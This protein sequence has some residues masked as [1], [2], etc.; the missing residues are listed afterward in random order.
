V[1]DRA[2]LEE[3]LPEEALPEHAVR[4]PAVRRQAVAEDR[5]L[6]GIAALVELSVAPEVVHPE[7]RAADEAL[8]LAA[9]RPRRFPRPSS[10]S[11]ALPAILVLQAAL[12]LRLIWSNTAYQDESLYLWAGRLELAHWSHGAP[13]PAFQTYLS[14]SPAVYPPLAA[15]ANDVGGLAAARILSLLFMLGA[16]CLLYG[17]TVRLLNR[18]SAIAAAALFA[19]FG[20]GTEL[21]AFATYDAMAV[22]LTALAAYLVVRAGPARIGEP[23]LVAAGAVLALAA[24]TKYAAALWAPVVICLAALTAQHGSW[25]RRALRATR[26]SCYAAAPAAAALVAAGGSYVRGVEFTTVHRQ[27]VTATPPLRVLDIAWGWLAL[28][29]LLGVLGVVLIWHDQ[30]RV[31]IIPLVL[32]SAALLAPVAQARIHD[33][34]SLH[35]QVVFGAWFLCAV[36]G[37]AVG[38]ISFLDGKLSQGAVIGS[39]LVAVSAGTGFSQASAIYAS[40]PSVAPAMPALARAIT[41]SRC[42]CLIT[43]E[44]AAE[45]YLPAADLTGPIIGPYTFSYRAAATPRPLSGQA[46]MAAAI[47]NGYFGAVELDGL[48]TPSMYR[49]LQR[50]LRRSGQYQLTYAG[51]WPA[52]PQ[53]PTQVWQRIARAGT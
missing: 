38:R 26:L 20:L 49:V 28:L 8:V 29:L 3:A 43:Q 44:S 33:V 40:W 12:S 18:R 30:G 19:T 50:S 17:T 7:Q 35:K 52:K 51:R 15:L 10:W 34:T 47:M 4:R 45:Y 11:L 1:L 48:R 46:A 6:A 5:Q 41:S 24:A 21:G 27:I 53:E 2:V 31:E 16:T 14:G 25:P 39:V 42:P 13:V 23:L 9:R 32:L 36:A 37:Y 22:L